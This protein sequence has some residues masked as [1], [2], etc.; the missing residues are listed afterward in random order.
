MSCG[1]KV[2]DRYIRA[3]IPDY[4]MKG[5]E[6]SSDSD[7]DASIVQHVTD[8]LQMRSAKLLLLSD[9]PKRIEFAVRLLGCEKVR[10]TSAEVVSHALLRWGTR[11]SFDIWRAKMSASTSRSMHR[12]PSQVT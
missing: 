1:Q 10:P 2:G 7:E 5:M 6:Y 9:D 4:A 8:T 12:K 11:A 3:D